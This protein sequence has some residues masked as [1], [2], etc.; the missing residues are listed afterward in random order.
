MNA[1]RRGAAVDDLAVDSS[2]LVGI[3]LEEAWSGAY[4][5]ALLMADVRIISSFTLMESTVV[6]EAR[7]GAAGRLALDSFCS[8]LDIQVAPFTAQHARLAHEAW[9]RFGKGRHPAGL[10]LGDC[11]AYALSR[12]TGLPLL[13]KG[14]DFPQTDIDLVAVEA[15]G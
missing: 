7:K 12:S 11:C 1:P 15:P 14:H 6:I 13:A 8:A 9:R 5:N 2:A 10:N 3:L 4:L